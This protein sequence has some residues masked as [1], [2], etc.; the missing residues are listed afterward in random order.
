[1]LLFLSTKSKPFVST[2]AWGLIYLHWR[3]PWIAYN[4]CPKN[5]NDTLGEMG[6]SWIKAVCQIKHRVMVVACIRI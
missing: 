5:V 3:D 6:V 4:N 1:M 2:V